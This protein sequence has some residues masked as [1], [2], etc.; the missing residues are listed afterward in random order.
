M[1]RDARKHQKKQERRKQKSK[2][3]RRDYIKNRDATPFKLLKQAGDAPFLPCRIHEIAFTQGMGNLV[4]A[5]QL[6]DGRVVLVAFLIDLYCLG[7]KDVMYRACPKEEYELDFVKKTY[8]DQPARILTPE[9]AKKLVEGAAAFAAKFGIRPHEDYAKAKAVFDGVD[10]SACDTPFHFG[11][12]GKPFYISGPNDG[13]D[14][15]N[16]VRGLLERNAGPGNYDFLMKADLLEFDSMENLEDALEEGEW[17]TEEEFED[18]EPDG[19][20]APIPVEY[21]VR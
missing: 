1:A 12:D 16:R 15:Q 3:K 6:P 21:T 13:F 20:D 14:F 17:D 2:E 10:S 4:V 9:E 8:K 19:I 11:K 7:V 5:R 18:G